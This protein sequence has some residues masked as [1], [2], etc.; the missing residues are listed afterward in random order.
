[1]EA[2]IAFYGFPPAD[3]AASDTITLLVLIFFRDE[4]PFLFVPD[5]K[6]FV[7]RRRK[8]GCKAEFTVLAVAG[9]AFFSNEQ[10]EAYGRDAANDAL[11]WTLDRFGRP[12]HGGER[13]ARLREG[14]RLP[15]SGRLA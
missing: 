5:S 2:Y 4:E 10:P 7:E 9:H 11:R 6:A 1:M 12:V 8:R 15:I 3:A 14:T 13:K